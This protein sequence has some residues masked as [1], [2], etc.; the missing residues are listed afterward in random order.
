MVIQKL[1]TNELVVIVTNF[2]YFN[3]FY[4]IYSLPIGN[5]WWTLYV[6]K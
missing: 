1:Y 5:I 2:E 6:S 3:T 4:A